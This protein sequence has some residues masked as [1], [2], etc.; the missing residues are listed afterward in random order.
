MK[1]SEEREKERENINTE[2]D[3]DAKYDIIAIL[4]IVLLIFIILYAYNIATETNNKIEALNKIELE[5]KSKINTDNEHLMAFDDI[6]VK[7]TDIEI[8]ETNNEILFNLRIINKSNRDINLTVT[9]SE[10]YIG[11]NNDD[12]QSK[13]AYIEL[14][15]SVESNSIQKATL[16]VVLNDKDYV[17][18]LNKITF[19]FMYKH[20]NDDNSWAKSNLLTISGL[21]DQ[22]II[23][24]GTDGTCD[25]SY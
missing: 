14:D 16:K 11:C 23:V 1:K 21:I 25:K 3:Y 15:K 9:D 12:T 24:T 8:D 6:T 20:T 13:T 19:A 4:S 7:L 10:V 2:K 22:N 18:D 5:R 17:Y